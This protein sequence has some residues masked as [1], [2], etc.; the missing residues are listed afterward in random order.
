M[1]YNELKHRLDGIPNIMLTRSLREL[2]D[3]DLIERIQFDVSPLHVE[4]C[5][6]EAGKVSFQHF[7]KNIK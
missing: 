1:R 7:L 5:L 3:Y 4:Y 2:E 6:S